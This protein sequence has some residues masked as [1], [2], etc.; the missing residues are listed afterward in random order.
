MV[1]LFCISYLTN[2]IVF[3]FSFPLTLVQNLSVSGDTL[4]VAWFLFFPLVAFFFLLRFNFCF[5]FV[6]GGCIVG[7]LLCLWTGEQFFQ[8]CNI[9][10]RKSCCFL[11]SAACP[12]TMLDSPEVTN[13]S[14]PCEAADILG[15]SGVYSTCEGTWSSSSSSGSWG[16]ASHWLWPHESKRWKL[17]V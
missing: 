13:I 9:F 8:H 6:L 15:T 12:H 7:F 14:L 11:E 1:F 10:R 16:I 5:C 17:Y 4:F 2:K 3:L